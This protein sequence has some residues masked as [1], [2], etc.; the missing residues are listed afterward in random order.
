MLLS[1]GADG[2]RG[3]G[4]ELANALR[5][6]EPSARYGRKVFASLAVRRKNIKRVIHNLSLVMDELGAKDDQLSEFVEN[7]N[8]VFTTLARQDANLR[9]TLSELPSALARDPARARQ[10]E[11]AGR[12]AR[13]D[14]AGAAARRARARPVAA[15][16]CA[17]S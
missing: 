9:A 15:S 10:G 16:R 2:L 5:R 14:A 13:A 8:A 1:A 12:R 6:I 4:K 7:S 11:G 3:N 17:R